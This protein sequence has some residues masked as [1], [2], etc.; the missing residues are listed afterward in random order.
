MAENMELSRKKQINLEIGFANNSLFIPFSFAI[1][2]N[3]CERKGNEKG[4]KRE[5]TFAVRRAF[6]SDFANKRL[7]IAIRHQIRNQGG[8]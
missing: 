5:S 8:S 2:V 1:S 4:I 7:F 6:A 3:S